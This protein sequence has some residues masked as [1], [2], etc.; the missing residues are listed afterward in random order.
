M[1]AKHIFPVGLIPIFT[2]HKTN[3]LACKI[4][5]IQLDIYIIQIKNSVQV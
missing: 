2:A 5:F 3:E 1:E 4:G